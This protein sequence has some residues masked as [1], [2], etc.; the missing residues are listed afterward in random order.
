MRAP[1]QP[2]NRAKSD[3]D[4]DDDDVQST[5]VKY[6]MNFSRASFLASRAPNLGHRKK[7][8]TLL[9]IDFQS[10]SGC[11]SPEWLVADAAPARATFRRI[12]LLVK[13]D[14][15]TGDF[16]TSKPLMGRLGNG[17]SRLAGQT[18]TVCL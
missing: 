16:S 10:T 7:R 6:G 12:C 15:Q 5:F 17:F 14:R 18:A 2:D 8:I 13:T 3:D 4:D 11:F 9:A 1:R